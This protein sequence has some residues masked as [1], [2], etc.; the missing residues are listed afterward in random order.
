MSF[1]EGKMDLPDIEP[2]TTKEAPAVRTNYLSEAQIL[3]KEAVEQTT[4]E[5]EEKQEED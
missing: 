1:Y 4:P 3:E 2:G 5:K